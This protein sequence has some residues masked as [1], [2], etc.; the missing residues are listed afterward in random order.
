[1][2]KS[3]LL[4][5][6]FAS[7]LL[8][9]CLPKKGG[10]PGEGVSTQKGEEESYTGN[11]EKIMS[12]GIP[13]KCTWKRDE[14]YYGESWI[15]GKQSYGEV[16]QEGRKTKVIGKDDCIW[17]WEEGNPQGTTFCMQPSSE[18]PE[19][20]Q[21]QAETIPPQEYQPTDMEYSCRPA[22]FGDDKFNPPAEIN[23]LNVD[24]LMKSGYSET[25][26]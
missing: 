11:I 22:V 19:L 3:L 15:K 18:T 5:L 23:F 14:N 2:K 4:G 6:I 1:M 21:E 25:G 7:F 12:L 20:P 10:T 24:E 17:A 9:G 13:V 16:T 8:T 26:D